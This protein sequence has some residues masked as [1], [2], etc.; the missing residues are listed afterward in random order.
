MTL[1]MEVSVYRLLGVRGLDARSLARVLTAWREEP[2]LVHDF[3]GRP[4]EDYQARW[5]LSKRAGRFL[6]GE[7]AVDE[8]GAARNLASHSRATEIELLTL[9]DRT[10]AAQAAH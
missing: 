5:Q 2:S 8:C 9:L 3:W 10:Y 7:S 6:S 1:E 4:T